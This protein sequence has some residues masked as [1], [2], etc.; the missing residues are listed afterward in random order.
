MPTRLGNHGA[1][2]TE[3]GLA[4]PSKKEIEFLN[5]EWIITLMLRAA[6]AQHTFMIGT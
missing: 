5:W 1:K 3:R 6:L 2:I 4:L